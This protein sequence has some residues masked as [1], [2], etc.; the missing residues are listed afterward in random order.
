MHYISFSET[1]FEQRQVNRGY[2]LIDYLVF[3]NDTKAGA[4]Q[5]SLFIICAKSFN[6]KHQQS[7]ILSS[8]RFLKAIRGE[9]K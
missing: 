5:N 3:A 1:Y 2:L 8:A 6:S 4:I 9:V 7:F